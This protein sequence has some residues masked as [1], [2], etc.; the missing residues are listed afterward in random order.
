MKRLI[1]LILAIALFAILITG[2][3]NAKSDE[4]PTTAPAETE[5][6][7]T[8]PTETD[9]P[10]TTP[11]ETEPTEIKPE[12]WDFTV[13][14]LVAELSDP[15]DWQSSVTTETEDYVVSYFLS[16]HN[17]VS[18][19]C[20]SEKDGALFAVTTS[21]SIYTNDTVENLAAGVHRTIT[22]IAN[23]DVKTAEKE[24]EERQIRIT[25]NPDVDVDVLNLP[26]SI[27][28][29]NSNDFFSS[30]ERLQT[31]NNCIDS[32]AFDDL[33]EYVNQYIAD[34]N[35]SESDNASKILDEIN[36]LV[37]ELENCSIEYDSFEE[38]YTARYNGAGEIGWDTSITASAS[39]DSLSAYIGFMASDWL[40]FDTISI[41][42]SSDNTDTRHYDSWDIERDVLSGGNIEEYTE[43]GVTDST[44]QSFKDAETVVIRFQNSKTGE[45]YDHTLTEAEKNSIIVLREMSAA[46]RNLSDMAYHFY[47]C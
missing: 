11:T 9:P 35:P 33:Q 23:T 31:F 36:N 45:T 41:K 28:D 25:Y 42:Y 27:A 10:T 29:I 47:N 44:Y 19:Y 30:E 20:F 13:E 8:E 21:I 24:T 5:P 46:Y 15:S 32:Y 40:F 43:F 2:C 34:Y 18:V 1:A 39:K 3:G 4:P 12:V 37:P 22:K 14:D 6:P 26:C 7:T 38:T 17:T 16:E